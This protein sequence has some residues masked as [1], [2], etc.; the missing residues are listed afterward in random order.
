M[1]KLWDK[2]IVIPELTEFFYAYLSDQPSLP[3]TSH[4]YLLAKEEH[5][6]AHTTEHQIHIDIWSLMTPEPKDLIHS[7]GITPS[8]FP[9]TLVKI[10]YSQECRAQSVI[11]VFP[12]CAFDLPTYLNIKPYG[13]NHRSLNYWSIYIAVKHHQN[14]YLGS[15]HFCFPERL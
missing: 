7:L 11:P 3:R 13:K 14:M 6:L 15:A 8:D 9:I 1:S 10:G 5:H 4:R 2:S 12:E